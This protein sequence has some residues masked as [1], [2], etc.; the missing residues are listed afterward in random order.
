MGIAI[1]GVLTPQLSKGDKLIM[2]VTV[3][4]RTIVEDDYI[5]QVQRDQPLV[6]SP[7]GFI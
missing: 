5:Y 3:M 6:H 7:Y 4:V 2:N 1:D